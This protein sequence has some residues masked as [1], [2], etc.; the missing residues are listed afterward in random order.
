MPWNKGI[1]AIKDIEKNIQITSSFILK[2]KQIFAAN[3]NAIKRIVNSFSEEFIEQLIVVV[4]ELNS[5]F[6]VLTEASLQKFRL[7]N[8]HLWWETVLELFS[9]TET[10]EDFSD[11]FL[12]LFYRNADKKSRIQI[13][14][15][16]QEEFKSNR[17]LLPEF[18]KDLTKKKG[19]QEKKYTEDDA[20]YI[21]NAGLV[22]LHPFLLQLFELTG[23]IKEN[24]WI[25]NLSQQKAVKLLEY[26]S[27]GKNE[28]EEIHFSLNKILCGL[29]ISDYANDKKELDQEVVNA[30]DILLK[31]VISFWPKLKNT[32]IEA[33]RETFLQRN[34]K[35]S[36]VD[37]GWLLQ[38]ERKAVD[39]LMDSLQWGIGTIKLPWMNEILYTDWR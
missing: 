36:V 28:F 7:I 3:Y 13:D 22:L 32:S 37:N 23:V 19:K 20:I 16:V 21:T 33:F 39:I 34:G 14:K 27:S 31:E 30:C 11:M 17:Q 5:K 8:S 26:L 12:Q 35:L 29:D 9:Y 6:V 4:F 38:I 10:S 1:H 25:D 15:F 24:K 2:L 18:E